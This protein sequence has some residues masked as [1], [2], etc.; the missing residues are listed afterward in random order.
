MEQ[1]NKSKIARDKSRGV[2]VLHLISVSQRLQVELY[3]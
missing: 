2:E 3:L 1:G